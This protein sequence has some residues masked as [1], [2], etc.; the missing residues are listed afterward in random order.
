[1]TRATSFVVAT[2]LLATAAL[3]GQGASG[4]QAAPA[5]GIAGARSLLDTYCAG[6]HSPAAKA[7]GLVIEP[8]MLS[9]VRE[10]RDVWEKSL[11]KYG[12]GAMSLTGTNTGGGPSTK[13][14]PQPARSDADARASRRRIR[15]TYDA[16]LPA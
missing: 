7:G 13:G 4:G 8:S 9:S 3:S 10:R 16:E 2:A 15:C 11:T 14:T 5:S 12:R 6:C 1:M